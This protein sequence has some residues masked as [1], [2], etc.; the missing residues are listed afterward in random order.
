MNL[1][2]I[3]I[4]AILLVA[5]IAMAV[6]PASADTKL[7]AQKVVIYNDGKDHIGLLFSVPLEVN[8]NSQIG[9]VDQGFLNWF[10]PGHKDVQAWDRVY[11]SSTK[12]IL[13]VPKTYFAFHPLMIHQI[14]LTIKV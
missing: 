2:R 14:Y 4:T 7:Y 11:Y 12:S 1:K 9:G 10:V 8:K 3:R 5:M 13:L 6:M